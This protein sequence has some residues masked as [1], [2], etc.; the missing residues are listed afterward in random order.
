MNGLLGVLRRYRKA[1]GGAAVSA[2]SAATPLVDDGVK[3]SEVLVVVGAALAGAGVVALL[4][5][6]P[7]DDPADA[8]ARDVER[9]EPPQG[10]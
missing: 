6:A 4:R 1:L 9:A 7:A 2:I 3:P 10:T 8:P 5:N